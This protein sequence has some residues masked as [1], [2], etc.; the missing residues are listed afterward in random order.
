VITKYCWSVTSLRLLGSVF[1]ELLPRSGLHNPVVP[2]L[3]RLLRR[4]G[5][6]CGSAVLHMLSFCNTEDNSIQFSAGMKVKVMTCS[7]ER[8]YRRVRGMYIFH[9]PGGQR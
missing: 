6:F 3:V 5:C 7:L 9:L 1:T 4:N 2:L 8:V